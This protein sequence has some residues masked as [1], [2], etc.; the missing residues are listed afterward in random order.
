MPF[1][2][3][4][5]LLF[6]RSIAPTPFLTVS[7]LRPLILRGGFTLQTVS[8]LR[9]SSAICGI[10]ESVRTHTFI[11]KIAKIFKSV[12]AYLKILF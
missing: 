3:N 4:T 1:I 12:R 8:A 11:E 5:C 6:Q 2:V 7:G 9:A 10:T